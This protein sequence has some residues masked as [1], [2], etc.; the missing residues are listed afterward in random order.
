MVPKFQ[1]DQVL[2]EHTYLLFE[3]DLVTLI[4][5]Y[6]GEKSL[7]IWDTVKIIRGFL[8]KTMPTSRKNYF[9]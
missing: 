6:L 8:H 3:G 9:N 4:I 2:N 5:D 7:T 1:S